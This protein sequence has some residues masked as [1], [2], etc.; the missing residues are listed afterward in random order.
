MVVVILAGA[1][2]EV[3]RIGVERVAGMVEATTDTEKVGVSGVKEV[4]VVVHSLH[5]TLLP[6]HHIHQNYST[7]HT[8]Y[9]H[10]NHYILS[11]NQDSTSNYRR[12]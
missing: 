6:H 2:V 9:T 7:V 5:R 3:E 4:V 1:K 10:R 8:P 12:N 11:L